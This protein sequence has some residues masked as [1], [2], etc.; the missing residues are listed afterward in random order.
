MDF[1][2][3][4]I[5]LL[6]LASFVFA[7]NAWFTVMAFYT[8][9]YW[10]MELISQ[11]KKYSNGLRPMELTSLINPKEADLIKHGMTIKCTVTAPFGKHL[12]ESMWFCF[13]GRSL[14]FQS[15]TLVWCCFCWRTNGSWDQG[16]EGE[17]L[18]PLR[19]PNNFFAGFL[20]LSQQLWASLIYLADAPKKGMF[21]QRAMQWSDSVRRW[22][23]HLVLL[24]MN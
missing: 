4:L 11:Q 5:M 8:A 15:E 23:F 16:V 7:Q 12:P 18:F 24:S 2:S 1:P 19:E 20:L 13:I 21:P 10:I 6:L 14:C 9:L 3:L 22:D 17:W